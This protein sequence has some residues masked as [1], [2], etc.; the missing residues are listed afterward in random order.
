MIILALDTA[1]G[2]CSAA[3]W[4]DGAVVANQFRRLDRGHAE[5]IVPMVQ[6]AL[7]QAGRVYGDVDAFAVTTGPGTYTGLRIGHAAVRGLAIATGKPVI[8]AT[9]LEVVAA[10]ACAAGPIAVA[11]RTKRADIYFQLFSADLSPVG[12]PRA[13]PPDA[14]TLPDEPMLLAGD[15]APHIAAAA[16]RSDIRVAPGPGLPEAAVL[17]AIA[18]RRARLHGLP[19]PSTFP[20]PLY[21]RAPDVTVGAGNV[22]L[23]PNR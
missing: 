4:A 3:V 7:G 5:A 12:S 10:A 6:A 1:L 16:G 9:T 13:L 23:R 14:V 8:G 15:A 17:A 2:A 20:P 22:G 18:G 21:L 19:P 11:L